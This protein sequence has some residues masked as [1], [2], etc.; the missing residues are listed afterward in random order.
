MACHCTSSLDGRDIADFDFHKKIHRILRSSFT[1]LYF[2]TT[3]L[4]EIAVFLLRKRSTSGLLADK[5]ENKTRSMRMPIR[6]PHDSISS[7]RLQGTT[8]SNCINCIQLYKY[9]QF[10]L[11]EVRRGSR[12]STYLS[13]GTASRHCLTTF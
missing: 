13:R 9:S 10:S 2:D 11:T 7:H 6:S 5:R 1:A 8:F 3:T 4:I 12:N